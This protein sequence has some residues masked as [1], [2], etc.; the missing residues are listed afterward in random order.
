MLEP[1]RRPLDVVELPHGCRALKEV[2]LLTPAGRGAVAVVAVEGDVSA[3]EQSPALFQSARG[4]TIAH[5]AIGRVLFGAWGRTTPEDVVVC[6][7]HEHRWEIHCHG[8][9][10]AV[11]RILQDLAERGL[12]ATTRPLAE[13]AERF[14][15]NSETVLERVDEICLEQLMRAKTF[16]TAE[17]LLQQQSG[18]L[19]KA[20][21]DALAAPPS[22]SPLLW[23]ALRQ[24]EEFGR[25]LTEPWKIVLCG[26]PNVGKSSLMNALLGYA[27]SIVF[28]RP[29]T[30]RDLLRAETAFDGW[31]IELCDT[32]GLRETTDPLESAGVERSR[33]Q[34]RE[35][36]LL[37]VVIDASEPPQAEDRHLLAEL[38]VS[39]MSEQSVGEIRLK[40]WP[41]LVAH[42]FDL[43]NRWGPLPA[44]S[45]PVSSKTGAGLGP[46]ITAAMQRLIPQV[47]VPLTP[48]PLSSWMIPS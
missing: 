17:I 22:E 12:V 30:T 16:R 25:H 47:P 35:A 39:A 33:A 28:D 2:Q 14:T 43:P 11:H 24:W 7:V 34:L 20:L 29:G 3:L 36:D 13:T 45:A 41:I 26:R 1:H 42:K 40:H 5:A 4:G 23:H 21:A 9:P 48:I 18:I 10:A 27:R 38:G 8:G 6:R 19:K 44:D 31:P 46:L 32:A 15:F 37:L